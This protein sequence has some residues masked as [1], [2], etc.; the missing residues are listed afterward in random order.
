MFRY[1]PYVSDGDDRDFASHIVT[2]VTLVSCYQYIIL[3]VVFSKGAPYRLSIF[4]N[5]EYAEA[6]L[7]P[8][9]LHQL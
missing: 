3:A 2:V 9:N 1:E 8:L 7:P 4:T 6:F 5:C